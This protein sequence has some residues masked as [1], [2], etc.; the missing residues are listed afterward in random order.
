MRKVKVCAL[1]LV[2]SC[3]A[4]NARAQTQGKNS[5][6][7]PSRAAGTAASTEA[8][9]AAALP[10]KPTPQ[11]A[12][13]AAEAAS[14]GS[15]PVVATRAE[16]EELRQEVAELKAVINRLLETKAQPA[17]AAAAAPVTAVVIPPVAPA[18]GVESVADPDPLLQ[19]KTDQKATPPIAGW[20]GEHFFIRSAD[21]QF[22]LQPYG[23]VQTDYRAFD[24]D[25]APPNTFTVRRGRFGFQG[26]YGSH[27]NFGLLVDGSSSSG[28]QIRDIFLNVKFNPQFN[29][30]GGQFK[31]FF[32]QEL[33]TGATNLDFVERGLQALLYP[34]PTSA[35]RSIGAAVFGDVNGGVMQYWGGAFNGKGF[36]IAN[37]S[38]VPEADF[39]LRFYPWRKHKDS[40][41]EGF[42][43]GG[44]LSYSQ[45]RGLSNELTPGMTIPDT[46]FAYFPQFQINGKVWRYNGDFAYLKGPWGVKAEYVQAT[47]DRTS[48]GT[49]QLGGLG[50]QDLP[51]VRYKAWDTSIT[52]LLTG[53]KRPENGTPRVKRPLFGPETPGQ[54]GKGWGALELAFRYSG[55]QGKTPNLFF[56]NVF[57]PQFFSGFSQHTNDFT[58]GINWYLNYWIKYQVNFSVNQLLQPSTI[59]AVPQTYFVALQRLQFRF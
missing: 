58:L 7:E 39:R 47:F 45:T 24:G 40:L 31:V 48:V 20:N 36:N 5:P 10:A 32:G 17:P 51:V 1:L 46:A 14:K 38:S 54:T 44:A 57:T 27:F 41:F 4:L 50:L 13:P 15:A 6:D 52:Y 16:V 21:G 34:D 25:G 55:I 35:F 23:Y 59:G 49:L 30:Q 9:K 18:E 26:N 28:A 56:N 19:A 29:F 53:E 12:A 11:P 42:S 3:F 22:R 37:T 33:A 43:F 8:A 2:A